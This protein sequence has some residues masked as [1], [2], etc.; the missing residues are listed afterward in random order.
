MLK[1]G[2]KRNFKS[3][4][5]FIMTNLRSYGRPPYVAALLHGGPGAAG[6]MTPV[7]EHLAKKYNVLEP[8]QTASS[9]DGQIDELLSVLIANNIRETR[10]ITLVGFSWGAWLAYLF[11]AKHPDMIKKLILVGSGSF[12]E[13]YVATMNETRMSRLTADERKEIES[14]TAILSDPAVTDKS[15]AFARFGSLFSKTDTYA[16]L[17]DDHDAP[18][19][20][21]PDIYNAV[22]PEAAELRRSGKLLDAGRQIHCPTLAIHGDYDPH[23][24]QGVEKPLSDILHDFRFILLDRCGHKPWIERHAR[25][26]FYKIMDMEL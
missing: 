14:L 24:A 2:Y 1:I 10:R 21:R 26:T 5:K 13:K 6:E 23:P 8:I 25:D 11:T 4:R 22:W 17:P 20:C 3:V 18:I 9:V 12:E 16:P 7:A 15:A 19:D